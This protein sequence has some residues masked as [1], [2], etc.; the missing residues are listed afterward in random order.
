M[1]IIPMSS[2]DLEGHMLFWNL[3]KSHIS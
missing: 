2:S 3:S 1:A